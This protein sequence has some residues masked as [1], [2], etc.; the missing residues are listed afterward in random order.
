VQELRVPVSSGKTTIMIESVDRP[1]VTVLP[2]GD[3]RPLLVLVQELSFRFR[4]AAG[5]Q[6]PPAES[7]ES[8]PDR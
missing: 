3:P 2:N 6:S 5:P 7:Q 4:P 1:S 8:P